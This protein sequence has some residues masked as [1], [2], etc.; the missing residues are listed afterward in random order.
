V[1]D[2]FVVRMPAL[3]N[4]PIRVVEVTRPPFASSRCRVTWEA[5]QIEWRAYDCDDVVVF[6]VESWARGCDRLSRVM[7]DHI[8]MAKE[9]Q[10][11]MWTRVLERATV[12]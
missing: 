2:E 9:V 3:W 5:G 10:L 4:G 7:D 11:H 6:E 12:A 1:G 8:P